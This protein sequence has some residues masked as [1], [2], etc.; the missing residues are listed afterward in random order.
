[1]TKSVSLISPS[2]DDVAEDGD[3]RFVPTANNLTSFSAAAHL[4][5]YQ[6]LKD[7]LQPDFKCLDMG[8]G[9]GYGADLIASLVQNVDAVDISK[10]AIQYA[11]E[12]FRR[13]NLRFFQAD[14]TTALPFSSSYNLIISFDVIEH[15]EDARPFIENVVRN[16]NNDGIFICGTPNRVQTLNWN[17]DWNPFHIREFDPSELNDLLKDYFDDVRIIGQDIREHRQKVALQKKLKGKMH[18]QRRHGWNI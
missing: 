10:N 8:C 18:Q 5:R 6:W 12:S 7:L 11:T 15:I 13:D 2:I 9:S 1:M 3:I 17:R 16:L 4:S 14:L